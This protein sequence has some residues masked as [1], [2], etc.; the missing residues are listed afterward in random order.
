MISC[1]PVLPLRVRLCHLHACRACASWWMR[2]GTCLP[3]GSALRAHLEYAL[4]D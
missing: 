3:P 4:L 2:G 1:F